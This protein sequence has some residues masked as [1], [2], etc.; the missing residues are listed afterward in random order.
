WTMAR[1]PPERANDIFKPYV[2]GKAKGGGLGLAVVTKIMMVHDG[3]VELRH[4]EVGAEFA[5]CLPPQ[6]FGQ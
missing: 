2:T 1:V 5:L 4:R 3:R 6:G